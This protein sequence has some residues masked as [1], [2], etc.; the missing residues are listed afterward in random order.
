MIAYIVNQY[1]KVSHTFI[2]REIHALER[3]GLTVRRFALR[4]FDAGLV[5]KADILERDQTTYLLK[6]G[7][8]PLMGA[9]LGWLVSRPGRF[10]RALALTVTM[11]PRSDRSAALHAITL[12]EA[13][14]MAGMIANAKVRHIHA[15]FGTNSAE[16][17]ML[18]S[19]LT[20]IP[21]SFT[22]HGPDEFDKPQF[23][24]LGLKIRH[25]KFVAAVSGYGA[26]QLYRWAELRDWHKVRVVRCGIE[27][28]Y[29]DCPPNVPH[30]QNRLVCVGRISMQKGHTLLAEAA[31][32]VMQESEQF[33]LVM[34]GEGELRP[35]VSALIRQKGLEE[36]MR[37]TGWA[38]GERVRAEIAAA[39]GLI[40]TS[41]AEGL[42][43]VIMEAM[44]LGRV[45]LATQ[46]AGIPELVRPGETGWLF[47]AGSV[48]AAANAIR[49]CL[50]TPIEQCRTMGERGAA[51]VRER[52]DLDREAAYLCRL[53]TCR[54]DDLPRRED[55]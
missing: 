9:A 20:G 46:I 14:Y 38:S 6:N 31:A 54:P 33:E 7:V 17:A 42:P 29:G 10:L 55:G 48:S 39:R 5:D 19:A 15:H 24:R 2:R 51:L 23:I 4:G 12:C 1:P 32:V 50:A 49:A 43:V 45:V 28:G 8:V 16:L 41:F 25:A 36:R 13:C 52:H 44:A 11:V 21:Y 26:G 37:I 34:V 40:L 53:F 22:V 3:A 47:P 30:I 27:P 35:Q 18:V